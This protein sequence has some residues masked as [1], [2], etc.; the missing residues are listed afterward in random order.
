MTAAGLGTTPRPTP[1]GDGPPRPPGAL[2]GWRKALSDTL[3]LTRRNLLH[4]ARDPFEPAIAITMPVMMVLLFGYVFGDVMAPPGTDGY[5][6]F[7][8]PAMVA[9]VMVYGVGGTASGIARD[10]DRDVMSRFRTLPMSPVAV[11]GARVLTDMARAGAEVAVLLLVG[12]AMGWR[13][14]DGPGGA[15]AAIGVLL[16]FRLALVWLGV[17]MGL[18]LP[19]PDAVSMVV[20]PLVFPVTMLSTS[21]IPSSAM[22]SWLAPVSEWNPLSAVVTATR[23]LFGNP[24]L[25]SDAWPSENALLLALAV[26]VLAVAVAA[27]LAVRRF[28]RLSR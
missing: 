25:P 15:A 24:S 12:L 23:D 14:E 11:L 20:Y 22:P 2:R 1:P 4:M 26:P 27:P 28:R 6:A 19:T 17:L 7:L 21:F 13:A 5:R 10:T 8:V 3:V 18:L 9:M 16:L